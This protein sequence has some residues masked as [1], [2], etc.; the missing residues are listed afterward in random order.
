MMFLN[1][2]RWSSLFGYKLSDICKIKL[3]NI[4]L[5]ES[6]TSTFS[7]THRPSDY[8]IR[9]KAFLRIWSVKRFACW[10][11]SFMAA[12]ITPLLLTSYNFL[13]VVRRIRKRPSNCFW[14][15]VQPTLRVDCSPL[16][17]PTI[18]LI[19]GLSKRTYSSS[20]IYMTS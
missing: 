12:F 8:L 7:V 11:S 4:S 2:Y 3:P 19:S 9:S 6:L 17:K 1:S 15:R 16:N 14:S 5:A 10:A 20:I 18:F 13:T